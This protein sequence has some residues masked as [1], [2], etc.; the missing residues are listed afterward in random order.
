MIKYNKNEEVLNHNGSYMLVPSLLLHR[1]DQTLTLISRN[2]EDGNKN[3]GG[4]NGFVSE[5]QAMELYK[6][7][8]TWFWEQRKSGLLP[9][10]RVGKTIYYSEASLTNIMQAD[11][12]STKAI[13]TTLK[14]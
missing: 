12:N 10:S 1:I 9:F 14:K 2:M 7:S 3:A 6:R 5:K 13:L 11:I 8:H 4:I